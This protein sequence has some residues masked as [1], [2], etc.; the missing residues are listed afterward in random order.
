M[1]STNQKVMKHTVLI[2]TDVGTLTWDVNPMAC[3]LITQGCP[4][5]GLEKDEAMRKSALLQIEQA[6]KTLLGPLVAETLA[7]EKTIKDKV[8]L[9]NRN[10]ATIELARRKGLA[11][12]SQ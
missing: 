12:L 2:F 8:Q 1:L 6:M 5:L 3:P 4:S 7:S 10:A 9:A 11:D